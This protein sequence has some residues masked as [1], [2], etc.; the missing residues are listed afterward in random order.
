MAA[1]LKRC[2][3]SKKILLITDSYFIS[4]VVIVG[5]SLNIILSTHEVISRQNVY[6]VQTNAH[7]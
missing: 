2:R 6:Q 3:F 7:V 1:T 5:I 4:F